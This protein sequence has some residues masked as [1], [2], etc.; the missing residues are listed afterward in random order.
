MALLKV[1]LKNVGNP[2]NP[3]MK[4]DQYISTNT[5]LI[6]LTGGTMYDYQLIPNGGGDDLIT[7]PAGDWLNPSV[8]GLAEQ[9]NY[10]YYEL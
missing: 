10:Y 3:E 9:W 5:H 2:N 4:I 7:G 6:Y 1:V 8:Q